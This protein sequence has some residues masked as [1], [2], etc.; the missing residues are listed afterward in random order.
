MKAF[1]PGIA[2]VLSRA[3]TDPHLS[4]AI[5]AA[6]GVLVLLIYF[7]IA[8]PAVWSAKPARRKA[9]ADVLREILAVL[10]RR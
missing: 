7:G 5:L 8:L 9:A 4:Q 1:D 10:R 6:L 3:A 2:V